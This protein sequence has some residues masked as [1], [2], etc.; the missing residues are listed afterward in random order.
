[1]KAKTEYKKTWTFLFFIG[2]L[3]A[4]LAQSWM[5]G[6]Y[7]M[8]LAQ[9]PV[10]TVFSMAIAFIPNYALGIVAKGK[11]SIN[12]MARARLLKRAIVILW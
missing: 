6:R 1:V 5:L 2:S 9:T 7:V 8:G 3:T 4:A 11:I 10:A 12:S